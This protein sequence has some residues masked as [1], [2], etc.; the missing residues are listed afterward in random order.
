MKYKYVR[1]S[2][3]RISNKEAQ[4]IGDAFEKCGSKTGS[5][6]VSVEKFAAFCEKP[7]HPVHEIWKRRRDQVADGA[8]RAAAAYLMAAVKIIIIHPIQS[9]PAG[10]AVT[11]IMIE[12]K[13]GDSSGVGY[14]SSDVA[15]SP[16]LLDLA[17]QEMTRQVRGLAESF[18][19][20]AGGKRMYTCLVQIATEVCAAF[21]SPAPKAKRK[22]PEARAN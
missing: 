16:D 17:E 15:N 11:T 18:A 4:I 12:D 7:Q 2:K 9:A 14:R 5:K 10:R 20:I 3:F 22:R 21:S 8:G 6:G 19:A 1:R 13:N